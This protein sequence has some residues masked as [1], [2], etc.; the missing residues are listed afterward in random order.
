MRVEPLAFAEEFEGLRLPAETVH[1]LRRVRRVRDGERFYLGDGEGRV[2]A[3][4]FHG[5]E[6][7]AL[8][9]VIS[10]RERPERI[11]VAM[12]MPSRERLSWAVQKLAELG[13]DDIYLLVAGHDRRQGALLSAAAVGRL[14][15][16]VREASQQ[17]E[18]VFLPRVWP[19]LPA[20]EFITTRGGE[21]A[22]LDPQGGV[23]SLER[24]IWLVGPESGRVDA[25]EDV[26]RY[27]VSSS[28]LRVESAALVAGA[29]MCGL[30]ERIVVSSSV[31]C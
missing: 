16:I 25:G 14:E 18:R 22:I 1:H 28:I 12:F 19:N 30:S 31:V 13:V 4:A 26:P 9:E 23:P 29:F 7:R 27:R 21:I 10:F 3:V 15:R 24:R 5:E 6:L 11:G 8:G 17:S 2:V 20:G